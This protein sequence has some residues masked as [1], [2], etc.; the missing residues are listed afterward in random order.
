MLLST[1]ADRQQIP[2]D[3]WYAAPAGCSAA[4]QL[5]A[6]AAVDRTDR[7]TGERMDTTLTL[8]GILCEQCQK[9]I[10]Y[11]ELVWKNIYEIKCKQ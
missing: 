2:I 11:D 1:D 7:R 5:L 4:N 8:L 10:L 6:A 3:R 9:L